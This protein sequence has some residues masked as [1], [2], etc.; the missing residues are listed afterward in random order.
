[1]GLHGIL[2]DG[3]V[4]V[5]LRSRIAGGAVARVRDGEASLNSGD[6]AGSDTRAEQATAMLT[7]TLK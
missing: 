4:L 5:M 6:A 1:M 3:L 7:D 2:A